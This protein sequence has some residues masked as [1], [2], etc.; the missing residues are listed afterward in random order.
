VAARDRAS[1]DA[2]RLT[3]DLPTAVVM[4]LSLQT[5]PPL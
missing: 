1:I 2:P 5:I 4:A 3:R